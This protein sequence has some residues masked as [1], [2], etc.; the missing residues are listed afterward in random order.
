MNTSELNQRFAIDATVRIVDASPNYPLIEINNSHA[1]ASIALHGAQVLSYQPHG[2]EPVLWVSKDAVYAEGKSVRGGVPICWPWFGAHPDADKAPHGFV[3]NC[4]WR[5]RS[6]QQRADDSTELV[7]FLEDDQHSRG[8]WPVPFAL[9]LRVS[10]G[11][12]LSLSLTMTNRATIPQTLTA[13]LHSYF[14]V[15][16][17][18]AAVVGGLEQV[19][20][21]DALQEFRRFTQVGEIRFDAEL[22]RIYEQ[23]DADE[24]IE[25]EALGRKICLHKKNSQ[26]TVVWNP[27]VDKSARMD[28][29]EVGGYR[30]MVC[31]ETGN[32]ARDAVNLAPG[33]SHT[34]GVDISVENLVPA[35]ND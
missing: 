13:A 21:L 24:W 4:F 29:F 33:M 20:Y 25:D 32:V 22:D 12:S 1:T 19:E 31:V 14:Y 17:I 28:D 34:L 11:Q 5:L 23:C 8:L 35:S 7:L 6:I 3:R 30:R 9:E 27:W 26:S 18:D 16:D 10:V 15:G 2:Q